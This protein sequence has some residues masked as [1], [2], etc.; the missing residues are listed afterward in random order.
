M[1]EIRQMRVSVYG[2]A[3]DTTVEPD[4]RLLQERQELRAAVF[5][6]QA[7]VSALRETI[8]ALQG[9]TKAAPVR[10]LEELAKVATRISDRVEAVAVRVEKQERNAN[11]RA[12]RAI[13]E[14]LATAE[15][16]KRGAVFGVERVELSW[17]SD[18]SLAATCRNAQG[19]VVPLDYLCKGGTL[20][21]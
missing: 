8:A 4:A 14:H 16:K 12:A 15:L 19:G 13:Y 11:Q 18:A 1:T 3:F 2:Y 10:I 9:V 5:A 7:D 17:L 21:L 20:E 6:T